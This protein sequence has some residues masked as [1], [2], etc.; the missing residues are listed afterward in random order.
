MRAKESLNQMMLFAGLS[1]LAAIFVMLAFF[2]LAN[3]QSIHNKDTAEK[4]DPSLRLKDSV[5]GE[6]RSTTIII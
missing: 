5:T 3:L 4:L 6:V 1:A 2:K